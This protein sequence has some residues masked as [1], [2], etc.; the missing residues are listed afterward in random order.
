V[1]DGGA[2]LI[3]LLLRDPHLLEGG[4]GSEDGA[5]DPDRVLPLGRS[6]DLDLHGGGSQ[7]RDL[8]LH[9]VGD[10]GEHGGTTREHSVGVEVLSDIDVALHDGVVGCLVDTGRLH[11][12]EGGLE[13]GLGASESL[14]ADRDHLAVGKFVRL[15]QGGAGGRSL[16][17]LFEVKRHIA[18]L[19]LDVSDN[20]PLGR[21]GETVSP[22]SQDLHQVVYKITTNL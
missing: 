14:V 4:E 1:D 16:H 20:F 10:S 8:L 19:L 18:Q 5:S 2:R 9:S 7:G 21:G 6:D 22:L 3:V 13:E 12:D 11:A 17:L 15:L